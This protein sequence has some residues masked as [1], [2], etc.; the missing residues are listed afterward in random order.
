MDLHSLT[1]TSA[2]TMECTTAPNTFKIGN[3]PRSHPV[4]SKQGSHRGSS[5]SQLSGLLFNTLS[6]SKAV[7]GM[8]AYHRPQRLK[9]THSQQYF[10]HGISQK[11]S[12]GH[13]T[14]SMG[15]L[16]RSHRRI[17]PRPNQRALQKVPQVCHR[18]KG[19][20]VRGATFRSG[21]SPSHLHRCHARSSQSTKNLWRTSTY[22]PRRLA[23]QTPRSRSSISSDNSDTLTS[24]TTRPHSQ[25]E[26][27]GPDSQPGGGICRGSLQSPRGP[28]LSPPQESGED[29][30]PYSGLPAQQSEDGRQLGVSPGLTRVG[31]GPSPTRSTTHS[32]PPVSSE[33][34]LESLQ[35]NET[36]SS[37]CHSGNEGTSPVVDQHNCP[38]SGRSPSAVCSRSNHL[39]RCIDRRLGSPLQRGRNSRKVGSATQ[40]AQQSPGN[41]SNYSSPE[42]LRTSSTEQTDSDSHRQYDGSSLHQPSGGHKILVSDGRNDVPIRSGTE[43]SDYPKGQTHPRPTKC[44]GGQ[45]ESREPD[46]SNGVVSSSRNRK[47]DIQGTVETSCRPI[48]YKGKS[49]TTLLREPHSGRISFTSRRPLHELGQHV[50]LRL[51]TNGAHSESDPK[52]QDSSVQNDTHRSTLADQ[53]MVPGAPSTERQTST[54]TPTQPAP[55]QAA[56]ETGLPSEPTGAQSS[57]LELI[58]RAVEDKGF[59]HE[60]AQK[61]STAVCSSSS[62]LYETRWKYF[63]EWCLSQDIIPERATEQAV[64]DFLLHLFSSK[65]ASLSTI[66]GYRTAVSRVLLY[67]QNTDLTSSRVI[68]DLISALAH[69]RPRHLKTFPKWDLTMVLTSLNKPPYEPLQAADLKAL[70]FKTVF[71]VWLASGAR[72]GEVHALDTKMISQLH[73]WKIVKLAPNPTFLAKNFNYSKG[74]NN[75]EGFT[76]ESL[77]HRVGPD[78]TDEYHL[79]PVRALRYYLDRTKPLRGD[80]TQLF[81]SLNNRASRSICKNTLASWVKAVILHAYSNISPNSTSSMKISSHEIR[82]LATS[83]AFYGNTAIDDI[84]K[85]GRWASQTTFTSFYL[86][87][88]ASDLEG[89]YQLGPVISAQQVIS[90]PL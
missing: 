78:M 56:G 51:P 75:F 14:G 37:P 58:S 71:L 76:L 18:R 25:P 47:L 21:N 82:A 60:V 39:Y 54:T 64:A 81:I 26:E 48:C 30:D 90:R 1:S 20:P 61:V 41:E 62:K 23:L 69:D 65:S 73:N 89:I 42:V 59:S 5:Q 24:T 8:A 6:T 17:L 49:Q 7:R 28:G 43:A 52:A 72:R 11:H 53:T 31:H 19:L 84:M 2:H 27:I 10:S 44:P 88:M 22:V 33:G 40:Q 34:T 29:Q 35:P 12:T 66:K 38:G 70:T 9:Q 77:K 50:G 45:T 55:P 67:S 68:A 87:D 4:T 80:T 83:T 63:K 86:R 79:C 85:A 46:T 16:H 13:D 74:S 15:L 3:L 36:H 57:R 32:T